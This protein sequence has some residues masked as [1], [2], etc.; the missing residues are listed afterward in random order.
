MCSAIV[1]VG[2]SRRQFRSPARRCSWMR[3]TQNVVLPLAD[4]P[5][6][7]SIR[8]WPQY[9]CDGGYNLMITRIK[10]IEKRMLYVDELCYAAEIVW[11]IGSTRI[12]AGSKP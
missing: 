8:V 11:I 1:A 3:S 4:G 6:S 2:T 9:I 7:S 12:V 5:V 10:Q